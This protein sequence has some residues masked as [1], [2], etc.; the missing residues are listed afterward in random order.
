MLFKGRNVSLCKDATW[1][2]VVAVSKTG[3]ASLGDFQQLRG[4]L[5]NI[6]KIVEHMKDLFELP[7]IVIWPQVADASTPRAGFLQ[8]SSGRKGQGRH[9]MRVNMIAGI[10]PNKFG[11]IGGLLNLAET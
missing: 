4:L 1:I 5:V 10:L 3:C 8:S 2:P 7:E 6:R 9:G 11:T